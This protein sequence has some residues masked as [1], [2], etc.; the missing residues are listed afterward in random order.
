MVH[1]VEA[2]EEAG[3]PYK[4]TICSNLAN[5]QFSASYHFVDDFDFIGQIELFSA[6]FDSIREVV[7]L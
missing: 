5:Y 7:K 4:L 1:F 2:S 6:S 3:I